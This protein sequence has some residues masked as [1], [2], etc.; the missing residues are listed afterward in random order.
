MELEFDGPNKNLTGAVDLV[1]FD[2]ATNVQNAGKILAA[3]H[4]CISVGHGAKHVVLLFFSDVFRKCNEY[5]LLSKF[6][7]SCQNIWGSTMH[8]P[9]AMFKHYSKIHI[10]GVCVGFIKPSECRMAGEHISLLRLL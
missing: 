1:F 2:G 5:A 6:C 3:L 7:K 8:K 10:N 9:S 4:P